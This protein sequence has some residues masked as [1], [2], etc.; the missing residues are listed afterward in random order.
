[1][2]SPNVKDFEKLGLFYL[3]RSFDPVNRKAG[4]EL[5][6]YDS[7]DLVT[8]AVC[9][10]M[11]GSGKTGLCLSLL[12]EA[13]IDNVPAIAIDPKGD[14]SNLLLTF[15]KLLPEDFQPWIDDGEASKAGV[16]PEEFAAQQATMWKKGLA[17][18]GED[19]ERIQKLKD[20][21][22]FRI[23]T[24]GS[25][26]GLSLSI[27]KSFT[28]PPQAVLDDAESLSEQVTT[29]AT[30]ILGLLGVEGDPLQ[31]RE[32]ILI[33]NIL[34]DS[35]AKGEDLDLA[36]MIPKIQTP[37]FNRVGVIELDSF[38]P[39]KDRFALAMKLNNLMSSPGF[40][41]WLEGDALDIGALLNSPS[42]KPKISI[43]SIAHLSDSERMFFVSL[44][45]NQVLS[46]VR[47][48]TGTSSLRALLYMDEIY[49]YFPPVATPPSKRPLLT[50][51]KQ[52]RA[53]GL[54]IVLATQNPADL[55][56]K[57]LSN[58]GTWF[59]GRLQAERDK[60]RVLEGLEGAAAAQSA[61]FD[62][63][64]MDKI[65]SGL[66]KR[67]F[68]MHNVHE[69]HPQVFQVRWALSYLRGP[70]TR[71]QIKVLM[72]P[73]KKESPSKAKA[74]PKAPTVTISKPSSKTAPSEPP[75]V[76]TSTSSSNRPLLPPEVPQFFLPLRGKTPAAAS[77][78]YRP[79]VLGC[80]EI[81]YTDTK[82][83][84]SGKVET[85]LL[86]PLSHEAV[87]LEWDEAKPIEIDPDDLEKEHAGPA[88][89]ESIPTPASKAK[90][91]SAWTKAFVD[92]LFRTQT[93]E[94]FKS[95]QLSAYSQPSESEKAFR[96]RIQ[97]LAK[98]ARDAELDRL[99]AK[100]APK[101]EAVDE[102]IVKA[103]LAL[104]KETAQARHSTL[105][106]IV[107][108]GTTVLGAFLNR[109]KITTTTLNK[110]GTAVR[111]VG[112]TM[113]ESDDVALAEQRANDARQE[114]LDLEAEFRQ[115]SRNLEKRF[116]AWNEQLVTFAIK[117]KKVNITAKL[118]A[119]V[120]TP[121]WSDS[122]GELTAAWE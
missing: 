52:A 1:M 30:S 102:K 75:S 42:G 34:S 69:D 98:E 54:G 27:L 44:L 74:A 105:S 4:D 19:G 22:D 66:G 49:G 96:V 88:Q 39:A 28:V 111:N 24:P 90:S 40:S 119:L 67:T 15:P 94:V 26:A 29:T 101:L 55:D 33:S 115:E 35:W 83:G 59:L 70:L 107:N 6:M 65:L 82:S 80:G 121:H 16:T 104:E 5:V 114:A 53:Y 12:E 117:P 92:N 87:T 23:Y 81:F 73:F 37:P 38:F 116:D 85:A 100:Y 71:Q 64:G 122:D 62:R 118:V 56:Y 108:L 103:D 17:E 78:V 41:G 60:M 95:E 14:L 21:A 79:M 72:D 51:L 93:L 84:V 58:T 76:S 57:G 2:F 8:H 86:A 106:S 45:L 43:I 63:A 7:R 109:K 25:Q 48:Q 46:W 11:T 50:L 10:G 68:L 91:Y 31:S 18:W 9:V 20:S 3:G 112:T 89:F 47:S 97:Q 120:W 32:H 113:K 77:L 61:A 110:A 99:R 36:G 13:A